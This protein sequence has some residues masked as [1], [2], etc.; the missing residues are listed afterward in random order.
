MTRFT[1]HV[2]F[3]GYDQRG[4]TRQAVKLKAT[5]QR[6]PARTSPQNRQKIEM[7]KERF[8]PLIIL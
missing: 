6:L 1:I 7:F 8:L 3:P 5:M 4:W 2:Y